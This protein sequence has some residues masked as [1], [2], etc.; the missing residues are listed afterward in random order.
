MWIVAINGE[1]PITAQGVLD[2]LNRH[3]TPRGKSKIKITLCRRKSYQRTDIEEIL[4][5]FDQV[6][7]V[8]SHIEVSIPKK[9]TTSKNIVDALGGPQRQFCKESLFFQY[10]KNKML[11][12]FQL[13]SQ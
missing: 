11:A 7:P 2:E 6:R 8:V 12:L 5:R 1:E 9:P 13:P 4:S 10:E 3:Q